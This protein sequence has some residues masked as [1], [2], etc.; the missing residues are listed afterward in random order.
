[1]MYCGEKV[2]EWQEKRLP[3]ITLNFGLIQFSSTLL[4]FLSTA[5]TLL[6]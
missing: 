3:F 1:M 5:V 4:S 2:E 6:D